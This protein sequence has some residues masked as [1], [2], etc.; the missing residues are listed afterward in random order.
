MS[1]F[2]AQEGRRRAVMHRGSIVE[3]A[4][5]YGDPRP[6]YTRKC[7]LDAGDYGLGFAANSLA[8]GCDCLGHVHYF[9]GVVNNA[10]GEAV[11][12]KNAVCMHEEDT[13]LLWKHLD[14]RSGAAQSRRARRLVL[15][16]IM[17]AINYECAFLCVVL[18]VLLAMRRKGFHALMRA[19]CVMPPLQTLSIGTSGWMGASTTR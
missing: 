3:M 17:T 4:V 11:V 1:Y 16:F 10:A 18:C 12:I 7:A 9:D 6:P 14:Y 19:P 5:P 15:S 8:L 2:D 13:G